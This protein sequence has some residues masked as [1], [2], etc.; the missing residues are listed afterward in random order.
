MKYAKLINDSLILAPNP[1]LVDGNWIG[2]PPGEVY[3]AEGYKPAVYNEQ[4]K[5]QG[6]GWFVETWTETDEALVQG[7]EW[8]EATDEDEISDTEAMDMLLGGEG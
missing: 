2:N 8:H 5:P 4:P 3:E 7:W 1:I 6:V